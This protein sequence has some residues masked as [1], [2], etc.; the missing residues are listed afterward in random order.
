[1]EMSILFKADDGTLPDDH[2]MAVWSQTFLEA[3][4]KFG[5]TFRIADRARNYI[6]EAG[7]EE[8]TEKKYKVPV[9]RWSS[10]PKLKDIGMWNWLHCDEGLEGWAMFL[11]ISVMGV[12]TS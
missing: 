4:E 12:S 6:V 2:I 1:M 11:L 9:G 3:G 5:K 7:F 8:V 10:D